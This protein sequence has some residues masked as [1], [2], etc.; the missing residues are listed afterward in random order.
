MD[1]NTGEASMSI[2]TASAPTSAKAS[3]WAAAMGRVNHYI[4]NGSVGIPT[5]QIKT[6]SHIGPG[7]AAGYSQIQT[8]TGWSWRARLAA[9]AARRQFRSAAVRLDRRHPIA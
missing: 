9:D 5:F 8:T 7:A 3:A 6:N 1:E 4:K 2:V